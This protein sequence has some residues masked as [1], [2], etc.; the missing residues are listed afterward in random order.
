M[1]W[2]EQV[3]NQHDDPPL[4]LNERAYPLSNQAVFVI[5]TTPI[6]FLSKGSYDALFGTFV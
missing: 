4:E 3:F 6:D 1:E 5:Y 2:I